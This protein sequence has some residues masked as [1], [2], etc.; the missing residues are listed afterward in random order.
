MLIAAFMLFAGISDCD[1]NDS[2]PSATYEI[3]WTFTVDGNLAS[4]QTAGVTQLEIKIDSV[5]SS[6]FVDCEPQ[7]YRFGS[8]NLSESGQVLVFNSEGEQLKGLAFS[9]FKEGLNELVFEF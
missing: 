7:L 2:G 8:D 5:S 1:E 9:S 4:C 3:G 6:T